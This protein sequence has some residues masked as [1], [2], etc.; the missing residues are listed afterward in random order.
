[1]VVTSSG[2]GRGRPGPGQ[3]DRAS[4]RCGS[5]CSSEAAVRFLARR[6]GAADHGAPARLEPRRTAARTFFGG[7]DA[8][9]ARPHLGRLRSASGH[10]PDDGGRRDAALPEVA[11]GRR[12]RPA[13]LRRGRRADPQRATP[14]R[15]CS[16][17]TTWSPAPSTDQ[18][19]GTVV[20][21]RPH[22]ARSR[23]APPPTRSRVWIDERLGQRARRARPGGHAL[24]LERPV[25]GD[26]HQRP[27][28]AGDG[29]PRRAVRR[30]ARPS[31]GPR[32][33]R[34]PG[35]AAAVAVL[36]TARTD[37]NG[38][39]EVTLRRHRQARHAARRDA[40]A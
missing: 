37:E 20:V 15:T 28:P 23:T 3:P 29:L 16:P 9:L 10:E 18:A 24:Q 33:D 11:G 4:P 35:R 2:A 32:R 34:G 38:I 14:C 1:M 39:H 26:D 25:P 36:L 19:L 31:T 17:S 12:A 21:L 7:L 8:R 30:P 5:G 13:Q 40:P 27:R 22:R 6:P